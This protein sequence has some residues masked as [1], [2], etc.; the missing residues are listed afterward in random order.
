MP[1]GLIHLLHHSGLR[2]WRKSC[3]KFYE[4]MLNPLIIVVHSFPALTR[5]L[6]FV[7]FLIVATGQN[8]VVRIP[9]QFKI[10]WTNYEINNNFL[11]YRLPMWWES[12]FR[13]TS[14][15]NIEY[16]V[17]F[18][19]TKPCSKSKYQSNLRPNSFW[20]SAID[21]THCF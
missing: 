13:D 14:N 16:L 3:L 2:N 8:C 15:F 1:R 21:Q 5:C 19:L 11:K 10:L 20:I 18:W 7:N 17:W 9:P 12:F 4:L 6:K